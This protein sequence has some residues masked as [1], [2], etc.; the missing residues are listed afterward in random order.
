MKRFICDFIHRGLIACGFGPIILSIVYAFIQV[1]GIIHTL[2]VN[3]VVLGILTSAL[4]AFI[5]GGINAIYKIERLPIILA[6]FIHGIIL[7]I[8]YVAIYLVND[9]MKADF[10]PL[11]VFT[12][13]F[14]AGFAIVWA[15]IYFH[16]KRNADKLNQKLAEHQKKMEMGIRKE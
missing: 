11:A 12:V 8:D 3:E 2:T 16:T 7:Y 4:L 13:C 6:I 5:A 10:V 9:W 15:M 1:D 14:F